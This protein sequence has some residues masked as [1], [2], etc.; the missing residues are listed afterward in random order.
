MAIQPNHRFTHVPTYVFPDDDAWDRAKIDREI[1]LIDGSVEPADG[2]VVSWASVD[3]HPVTR[4]RN[5]SSR[6]DLDTIRPYLRPAARPTFVVLRRPSLPHWQEIQSCYEREQGLV[7][8]TNTL[9]AGIRFALEEIPDLKIKAGRS[10]LTDQQIDQL[11]ELVGDE[12]FDLLG[13]ACLSVARS[14]T[15]IESFR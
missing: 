13:Y 6:F 11:R 9:T 5:G 15:A 2:E 7:G 12:R 10:G 3:D 8:R 4:Y 14:L 1:G